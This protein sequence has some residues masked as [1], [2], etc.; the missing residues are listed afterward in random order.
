MSVD[1]VKAFFGA[2][3]MESRVME[4]DESSATVELAAKALHVEPKRIAKTLSF[5][6]DDG[7][8]LIV[9][10]GDARI[11][12][13]KYKAI[14]HTK[15]RML[16][17][18]EVEPMT[19]AAPG[20]VCPFAV[21]ETVPVYLDVSLRRFGTVFP[22]CGSSN[23]AIELSCDELFTLSGARAWID[24]TKDWAEGNDPVFDTGEKPLGTPSDGVIGLRLLHYDPADPKTGFVPAY[25]FE[26]VRA[27]DG[28]TVGRC[29]L[30]LG[31]V[32]GTYFGGNIG[33]E[34]SEPFRGN[35][36]AL[37]AVKLLL[38]VARLHGMP[39]VLIACR[40]D[41]AA[42]SKT[43]EAAGGVFAETYEPP[44][45]SGLYRSGQTGLHRL[46]RVD[47]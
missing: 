40:D 31:F 6:V 16:S 15:A 17:H 29:D 13:A 30:R 46:Y 32:R 25:K 44:R 5:R 24:V 10:A 9:C 39:Y 27:S 11:D 45:Y 23:S 12:N 43:I 36:Y 26:I 28:T 37:R 1:T 3:G 38:D 4:F 7:C 21:P 18:D 33:Y 42:S 41:N 14:F 35:H 22:A 34:V 2:R 20:G 47:L 19:G 8:V